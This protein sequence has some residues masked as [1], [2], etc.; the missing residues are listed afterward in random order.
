[1]GRF[2]E[3]VEQYSKAIRLRPDYADAL[4]N[5]GHA[6]QSLGHHTESLADYDRAVTLNPN[7]PELWFYR[8][9]ALARLHRPKDALASFDSAIQ[10][11]PDYALAHVGRGEALREMKNYRE[12]L[13]AFETALEHDPDSEL[14][15]GQ[16]QHLRMLM[17]DWENFEKKCSQLVSAINEGRLACDPLTLLSLVDDPAI[18]R[19]AAGLVAEK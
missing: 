16:I 17:C 13:D 18:H 10:G 3:A 12:S 4:G 14:L 1:L 6:L 11:K 9:K 19:R 8:G 5:R 7:H 2:E 15:P